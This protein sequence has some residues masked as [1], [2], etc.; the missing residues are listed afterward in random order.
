[1]MFYL[2][3]HGV[4]RRMI[5]V[6]NFFVFLRLLFFAMLLLYETY[7]CSGQDRYRSDCSDAKAD[8]CFS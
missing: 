6:D 8:V 4:Q 2:P 1:M 5:S 7:P 3:M